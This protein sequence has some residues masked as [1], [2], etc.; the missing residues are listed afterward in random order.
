MA[1]VCANVALGER[2]DSLVARDNGA[3]HPGA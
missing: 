2:F 3:Q 1:A